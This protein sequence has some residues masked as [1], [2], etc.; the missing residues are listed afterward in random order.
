MGGL[1]RYLAKTVPIISSTLEL[2]FDQFSKKSFIIKRTNI[3]PI[4]HRNNIINK[5][6]PIVFLKHSK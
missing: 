1:A 4:W 5:I 2:L 3:V 6:Y